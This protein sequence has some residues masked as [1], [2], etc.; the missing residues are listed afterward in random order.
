MNHSIISS[1]PSSSIHI[2]STSITTTMSTRNCSNKQQQQ[3]Q[4]Q[5]KVKSSSSSPSSSTRWLHGGGHEQKSDIWTSTNYTEERQR[6]RE[7]WLHLSEAE[8][9]SL[10]KVEKEAVLR[11]MKEQ[12]RHS[13]NCSVCGKKRSA[14]EEELEVLYDAYYEE[15]EQ[16]AYRQQHNYTTVIR[17]KSTNI[18]PKDNEDDDNLSTKS[19][20]SEEL[21]NTLTVQ[22]SIIT[23]ADD[24]L[25]NDGKK[26]LD[27]MERLA[28]R[29]MRKEREVAESDDDDDDDNED[30]ED[31][32]DDDDEEDDDDHDEEDDDDDDEEDSRT[33]EQRMEEGRKMFQVFAARMFEQ[34]VLTAYR[35]KVAQDRQK[36]LIEELEE[37]DRQRQERELKKQQDKEKK[38]DKKRQ[39]KLQ[40]EKE[41]LELEDLKRQ[42][43]LAAKADR[44]QKL[45]MERQIKETERLKRQQERRQ[46]EEDRLRKEEEKKKRRL[47]EEKARLAEKESKRKQD[48]LKKDQQER[49]KAVTTVAAVVTATENASSAAADAAMLDLVAE[50]D[51][52]TPSAISP[53]I[54][55]L[56]PTDQ[57]DPPHHHVLTDHKT[58]I[59]P[60]GQRRTSLAGP[61][62]SPVRSRSLHQNNMQYVVN[63]SETQHSFFSNFLF[64][65]A[66]VREESFNT[67]RRVSNDGNMR[68][69]NGWTPLTALSDNVHG[70]LFG[71]VLASDRNSLILERS[72]ISYLKLDELAQAK[73][74]IIPPFHT[75]DQLH[76]ML[77]D[78]FYDML[79]DVRELYQVLNQFPASGLK[80]YYNQHQ[81]CYIV[82]YHPLVPMRSTS[83]L[84]PSNNMMMVSP[85]PLQPQHSQLP[86]YHH[87]I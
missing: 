73:F 31:D 61:I 75:L 7:F 53:S 18:R 19:N 6:I 56:S 52:T 24:L 39:L 54:P 64:G 38:R 57:V 33:E 82:Q 27:M 21:S 62:G 63:D 8:R 69:S 59:A 65:Q 76:R 11:K 83:S 66:P 17:R 87:N 84:L 77:H 15:L 29:K 32:D 55:T 23:V 5:K 25:K 35:E 80:C 14:I 68:W 86:A 67:G 16:Y 20:Q 44:D 74:F 60:I 2:I 40:Q 4:Q 9:R 51:D 45:K 70:K 10:V 43:E 34:R 42:E 71:D 72:R 85:P 28:E 49:K 26:F 46:K 48:Q 58:A 3:Q 22:G 30:E 79:I 50:K 41:R 78:L 37:E 36:R 1:S 47:K 81:Q 13:C 12:Q